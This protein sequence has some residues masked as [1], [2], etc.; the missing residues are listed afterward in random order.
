[1]I[2]FQ[3]RWREIFVTFTFTQESIKNLTIIFVLPATKTYHL[4]TRI[5]IVIAKIRSKYDVIKGHQVGVNRVI[6]SES[7]SLKRQEAS[8]ADVHNIP[9]RVMGGIEDNRLRQVRLKVKYDDA[10]NRLL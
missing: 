2:G 6:E 5:S 7:K 8:N 9:E 1:M 3:K 4:S 10:L